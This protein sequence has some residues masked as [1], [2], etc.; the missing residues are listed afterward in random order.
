MKGFCGPECS[1]RLLRLIYQLGKFVFLLWS[2]NFGPTGSFFSDNSVNTG[3][4]ETID[5][6]SQCSVGY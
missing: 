3:M 5:P 1:I 2:D 6:L 4:V